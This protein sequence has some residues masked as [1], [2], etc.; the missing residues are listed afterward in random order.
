MLAL[1]T[2]FVVV[3]GA[4]PDSATSGE[5]TAGLLSMVAFV[6]VAAVL[7]RVAFQLPGVD[8]TAATVR[9]RSLRRLAARLGTVVVR[10]PDAPGR[11]RPRAPGCAVVPA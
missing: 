5:L 10:D 4:G 8:A 9:S 1:M 3:F 2:T 7:A 6:V 11:T